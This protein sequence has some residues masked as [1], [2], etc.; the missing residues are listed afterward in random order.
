MKST[1]TEYQFVDA[2]DQINRSNNFS[3]EGRFALYEWLIQFEEDTGQELELDPIAFCCD[4]TEY[5]S[6]AEFQKDYDSVES[7]E[8]LEGNTTVIPIDDEAFIIQDY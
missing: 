7:M 4:F 2:F 3:R 8:E 5:E 1:I 6:F